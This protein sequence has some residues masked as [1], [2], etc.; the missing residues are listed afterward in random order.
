L[1]IRRQRWEQESEARAWKFG[2]LVP[3]D[4]LTLELSCTEGQGFRL[5]IYRRVYQK[6][7]IQGH[8][9]LPRHALVMRPFLPYTQVYTG[10]YR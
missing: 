10:I 9:P 6:A 2:Y 7:Y 3:K 8:I 1:K 5:R 4:L